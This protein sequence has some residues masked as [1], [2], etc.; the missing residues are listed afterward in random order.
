MLQRTRS[1]SQSDFTQNLLI[2]PKAFEAIGSK[3]RVSHR[4]F[5]A[6]VSEVSLN[7]SRVVPMQC[8]VVPAGVAQ[9]VRV[10]GKVY[11]CFDTRCCDDRAHIAIAHRAAAFTDKHERAILLILSLERVQ[12]STLPG[13]NRVSRRDP[14]LKAIDVHQP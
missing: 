11:L 4:V 8:K 2:V 14:M 3:G 12:R 5:N 6:P 1:M 10:N 9:L 7:G 13:T